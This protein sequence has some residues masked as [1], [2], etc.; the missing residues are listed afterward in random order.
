MATPVFSVVI[1][2]RNR[3]ELL[4]LTLDAL[5]AQEG[6]DGPIEVI[7]VD[8]GSNDGTFEG[9][10]DRT[11]SRFD[12]I[13]LKTE[14]VGP[15]GARN[16]GVARARAKR[17]L[18]LGDDTIPETSTLAAHLEAAEDR[19]VGVQG[20]IDWDPSM[21][22]TEVM[23]FLA[24]EGPQFWFRGLTD[25]D[26]VSFTGVYGSNLSAPTGWFRAEPFDE[27]FQEACFEDTE[28]AY[29]WSRR[30]W[31]VVFGERALCRHHHRYDTLDPVLDRQRRAGAGARYA[32]GKHPGLLWPLI[33]QPLTVGAVKALMV[34]GKAVVGRAG[35][36]ERA[37][38]K[39]RKAWLRG[40]IGGARPQL[41]R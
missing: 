36:A 22:I 16:L 13:A 17:T 3:R 4:A 5:E 21:E 25:G 18:L 1:P 26:P 6:L 37:D 23:R 41:S 34:G 35:F 38:L 27:H 31:R 7:V 14:G 11:S 8:D 10:R 28:Q 29:R 20:R 2:T 12:L 39:C 19:D 30:G 9:I 40:L 32:V 15:A 33:V 24:P